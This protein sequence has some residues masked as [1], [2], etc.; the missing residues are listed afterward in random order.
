MQWVL[1]VLQRLEY[2]RMAVFLCCDHQTARHSRQVYLTHNIMFMM[3]NEWDDFYGSAEF[4]I[5]AAG[6]E[7]KA[8]GLCAH[9]LLASQQPIA[10]RVE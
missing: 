9:R 1:W 7:L 8:L 4:S 5:K 10:P 3:V 6:N 2:T